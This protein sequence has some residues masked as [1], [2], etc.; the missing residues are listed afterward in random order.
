MTTSRLLIFAA[1]LFSL[2]PAGLRAESS[3]GS[4]FAISGG[5]LI[6]TNYHV[7]EGCSKINLADIG[8]AVLLKGDKKADIAILKPSQRLDKGLAFRSGRQVRLAEEIVVIGFPLR[9]VL[10]S[11]PTV[12]T[13]IVS[14]LAGMRD[15]RTRM[16]ISAPVQ[17]GNSGGPVLDRS[18]NVVGVV[19]SKLDAIRAA[20]VTGDIPQNVNFAIQASIVMSILDSYTLEYE[21]NISDKDKSLSDIAAAS[22]PAV[23]AIDCTRE[24]ISAE[25]RRIPQQ[26]NTPSGRIATVCGREVDYTLETSN[27]SEMRSK[28]VGVWTGIWSNASR[29]CGGLI[30]ENVQTDGSAKITYIY[31][32]ASRG[33][34]F[35]GSANVQSA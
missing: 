7:I 17:A 28:F 32:Q 2:L 1:I 6:V 25:A 26:A 35:S 10:S 15:D 29:I 11:P 5:G 21:S 33:R 18:G 9:G 8:S 4:G 12:T 31:G 16:Q 19:V 34:A 13:G 20:Q 27:S 24:A 3:S 22:L 14:S 23:V 30:V